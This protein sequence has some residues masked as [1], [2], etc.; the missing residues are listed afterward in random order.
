MKLRAA[1]AAVYIGEGDF[2]Q[3]QHRSPYM[4]SLPSLKEQA[5]GKQKLTGV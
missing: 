4:S 5:H 3:T 2:G 1:A